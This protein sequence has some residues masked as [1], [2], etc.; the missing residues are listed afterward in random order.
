MRPR[1]AL[2]P[3]TDAP[4]ARRWA[5]IDPGATV[6][7]VGLVV[8]NTG[9][10]AND[11]DRA[12]LI[13][14]ASVSASSA[15]AYTNAG[16]RGTLMLRVR[17]RLHAW[18]ITDVAIEENSEVTK[19]WKGA[20]GQRV[21]G[22]ATGSAFWQGTHYGLCLGAA[23]SLPWPVHVWSYPPTTPRRK[24]GQRVERATGEP[25]L[26]WMQGRGRIA[27]RDLTLAGMRALLGQLK[28]RPANGVL[29]TLDELRTDP[30]EHVLM[31]LGVLNFHLQRERGRV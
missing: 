3:V 21:T 5:G 25:V 20:D 2:V 12:R 28:R 9:V 19:S 1:P 8:P 6:G 30:V 7:L 16:A 27:P 10:E 24:Q 31:G 15:K 11:I 17:E 13:G 14:V 23:C 4:A 18:G 29:P 22:Q 26:G